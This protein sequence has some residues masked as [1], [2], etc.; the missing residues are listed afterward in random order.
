MDI[1]FQID[2]NTFN[3][4]T[5]VQLLLKDIRLSRPE[6]ILKYPNNMKEIEKLL[7]IDNIEKAISK[8]RSSNKEQEEYF[9]NREINNLNEIDLIDSNKSIFDKN[10]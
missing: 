5:K 6:N 4:N 7:N 3:G 9:Y 10:I 2:E 1:V 8:Y